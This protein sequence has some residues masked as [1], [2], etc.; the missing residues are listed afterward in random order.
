MKVLIVEPGKCP[1]EADIEHTLEAEQK[2]VGGTMLPTAVKPSSPAMKPPLPAHWNLRLRI[3]DIQKY[4]G[5]RRVVCRDTTLCRL[6]GR[7]DYAGIGAP[8]C[9]RTCRPCAGRAV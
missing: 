3:C 5:T 1:R 4:A 6:C 2:I 9:T 8:D 7:R